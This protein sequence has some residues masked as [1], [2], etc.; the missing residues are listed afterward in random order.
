[1]QKCKEFVSVIMIDDYKIEVIRED[2]KFDKVSLWITRS[3]TN[4]KMKFADIRLNADEDTMARWLKETID[5]NFEMKKFD[6]ECL[7]NEAY[8]AGLVNTR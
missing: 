6:Y 3:G 8:A 1:M 4:I 7:L 5:K 2:D